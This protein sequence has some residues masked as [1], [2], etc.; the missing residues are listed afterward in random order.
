M[1]PKS[2]TGVYHIVPKCT[3]PYHTVPNCTTLYQ[4]VPHCTKLY[5]TVPNCTKPYQ[6][7]PHRSCLIHGATSQSWPSSNGRQPPITTGFQSQSPFEHK[8]IEFYQYY[9]SD[10]VRSGVIRLYSSWEARAFT[11]I[12][13]TVIYP[14]T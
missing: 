14:E 13:T 4:T 5:H 10:I 6:M 11:A 8:S 9:K 2:T 1:H 3:K 12:F 7:V